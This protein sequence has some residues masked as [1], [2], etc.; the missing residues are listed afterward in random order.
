MSKKS[1]SSRLEE[2]LIE[3]IQIDR[4]K[5]RWS[6]EKWLENAANFFLESGPRYFPFKK[7]K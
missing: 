7:S 2:D 4:I 1:I 3:R 5:R 6:V